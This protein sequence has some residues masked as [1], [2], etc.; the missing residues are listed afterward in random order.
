LYLTFGA[1]GWPELAADR[2]TQDQVAPAPQETNTATTEPECTA[3]PSS[4]DDDD[5][6]QPACPECGGEMEVIETL[7]KAARPSAH[8]IDT[9][10]R[11]DTS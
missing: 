11:I 4:D 6:Q 10:H 3:T 9:F 1:L 8:C 7:P 5:E 2:S